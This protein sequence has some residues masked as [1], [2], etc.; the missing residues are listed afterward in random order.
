VIEAGA[1]GINFEDRIVAGE[2]I[3]CV[4]EQAARIRAMRN[5]A[6]ETSVPLFITRGPIY[7]YL[8]TPRRTPKNI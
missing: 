4:E 6:D 1:I 3:Y 5:A 2:G 8:V 7:F